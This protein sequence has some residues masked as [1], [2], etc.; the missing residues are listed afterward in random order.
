MDRDRDRGER[1][2]RPNRDRER[3]D[4]DRR[5]MHMDRDHV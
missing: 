4:R 5:M 3:S 2:R 1:D